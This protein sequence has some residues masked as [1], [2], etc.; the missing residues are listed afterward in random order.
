MK[1]IHIP[2][3]LLIILVTGIVIISVLIDSADPENQ[4]V[5]DPGEK[6][7]TQG[8]CPP[9]YLLTEDGDT[10]NPIAGKNTDKPYSPKQ[11]CG[12][13]HDYDLITQG[14][15]FQQG[16]DE[17]PTAEQ[18]E[19]IQWALSPGNY[20]GSWCSPAPL[21]SYLSPKKNEH[22]S[23]MDM[24]SYTFVNKCGV[25]H[26]GGGPLEYDRDNIR[27]DE[28]TTGNSNHY[29][30]GGI[31]DLDGD[32]YKAS[33]QKS[34]VIEA[35]CF[36]CHLP[37]YNNQI[38]VEQ[39]T[40]YNF[41]YAALA[42]SGYG[43]VTGSVAENI[44]VT[45]SYSK[46]KFNA[47]G[48][49]EPFIVKE[50]RNT[51]CLWC[52]AK[53]GYKKRGADFRPRNDVHLQAGLKCVDCH[54]AGRMATDERIK[55]KEI[56]QFGKGDDPSGLVR[57]DLD[58]TMRTCTDCHDSGYLGAPAARHTWL[59]PV[60]LE[61][62]ACQTC[63]IPERNVKS[64]HFVASD[65]F[66]PGT[67]IPTKGKYL[68]TFYGPDMNYWNHYGDLEMMG[69]DDKPT[70][71]FRPELVKYKEMIYPANRVHTA[72]PGIQVNG[73]QG[74]MQPKMGDIYQMW[75]AHF[76]DPGIYPELS[77]IRDDNGDEVIEVNK[78]EEI[79]ALISA[80]TKKLSDIQY[81][82]KDK[83]VVWVMNNRIF[84]S[85]NE[86]SEI[87]R[88]TWEASPYG[89][90]HTYNHD[91]SPAKSAL[92]INGCTDCHSYEAAFFMA[93]VVDT[94]I[95][96]SGN[97]ILYPQYE[98]FNISEV[99]AHVG[100]VRESY[101]KPLIYILLLAA[102]LLLIIAGF[103]HYF[104]NTLATP[105]LNTLSAAL[106]SGLF[107][108]SVVPLIDT[109]LSAYMLPSRFQLDSNHFMIGLAILLMTVILL[110]YRM[111]KIQDN[112]HPWEL[113]K[114]LNL[115]IIS[116]LLITAVSGLLMMIN[117]GWIFYSLFDL[118]L[119][120]AVGG[121]MLVFSELIFARKTT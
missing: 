58:N 102:M 48:T 101:I 7:S 98:N 22:E 113:K 3:L 120:F 51:A 1:T 42:G 27:Y 82:M 87:P 35:D 30:D 14:F 67:K 11:T 59:P 104:R 37:D 18:K 65:V 28:K 40:K 119:L 49:V 91:I 80:I 13:C 110:I 106:F 23:V 31:N 4:F 46:E 74:L 88:D 52:H 50:P 56:H 112:N 96:P 77:L 36:I 38:R 66:N 116:A 10:I 93:P 68:W 105:W 57:N 61:K 79:D 109:H 15:H 62:I 41:R 111:R 45:V 86:Y 81:P 53:P 94:P 8:V 9:L 69:Y 95:D 73:Q 6:I 117:A 76:K 64:V 33:W 118:G 55:G 16:R 85:G 78:P 63:H 103:R 26:P 114:G 44:P 12:K 99:Q 19:R 97:P 29:T 43:T 5:V 83:K 17:I 25:C 70:F 72:W 24:T 108:V 2:V 115:F 90:V 107:L 71:S 20:G 34:G 32:Y 89:N 39:I 21:Y 60:H 100:I 75:T 121:S 47:D 84:Q 54:P 92:G